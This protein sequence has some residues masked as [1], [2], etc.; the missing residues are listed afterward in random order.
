MARLVKDPIKRIETL[1]AGAER[2]FKRQFLEMVQLMREQISL[3]KLI[4]LLEQGRVEQ[5]LGLLEAAANKLSVAWNQE[6]QRA[7][8]STAAHIN[9]HV[10]VIDFSFDQTNFAAVEAMRMNRLRLIRNFT[11]Q[12]RQTVRQALV[13]GIERGANPR[14]QARAFRDSIGLTPYQD[15]IVRNYRE[16]LLAGDTRALERELRDRRFD[17][18]VSRAIEGQ[19]LPK[20]QIDKMVEGYR[21]RMVALRAETIS[22]TEALRAVHEGVQQTYEQGVSLGIMDDAQLVRTWNTADDSRVRHSHRSM[23]GQQRRFR[24]PFKTGN[25]ASLMY[26]TDPSGPPEDTIN[27]RCVVAVTMDLEPGQAAGVQLS[28]R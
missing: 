23:D 16:N 24:E 27:C 17:G 19:K 7:G 18:S 9:A 10:P 11:H 3:T 15:K 12:Q 6:F 26:P 21:R 13:A 20:P 4:G 22:R 5:A 25:G 14:E 28:I 2:R 1:I 8:Y